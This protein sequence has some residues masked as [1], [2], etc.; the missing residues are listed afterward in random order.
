[1]DIIEVCEETGKDTGEEE[2]H[3]KPLIE[4]SEVVEVD[5]P[6]FEQKDELMP[7]AEAASAPGV[8]CLHFRCQ[9]GIERVSFTNQ[10]PSAL[11]P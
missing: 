8:S 10:D 5:E 3:E 2:K 4:E 11:Y 9:G 7:D 6:K 1:M